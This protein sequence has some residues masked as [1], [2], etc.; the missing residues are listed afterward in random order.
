M[1][2]DL[3]EILVPYTGGAQAL[4]ATTANK[5]VRLFGQEVST[6]ATDTDGNTSSATVTAMPVFDFGGGAAGGGVSDPVIRSASVTT[7]LY[8]HS[9]PPLSAGASSER[10]AAAIWMDTRVT[11]DTGGDTVVKVSVAAGGA[12]GG[13][14]T[15]PV[16]TDSTALF[17]A[18][19]TNV[20]TDSDSRVKA[21][22]FAS[23]D[24]VWNVSA[25]VNTIGSLPT[26]SVNVNTIGSLP[27]QIVNVNTIGSLPTASVNVNTIGSLPAVN[28]AANQSISANVTRIVTNTDSTALYIAS[29][30]D[31]GAESDTIVAAAVYATNICSRKSN[32]PIFDNADITVTDAADVTTIFS[33]T[34]I[35]G[36]ADACANVHMTL[37]RRSSTDGNVGRVFLIPEARVV[38]N[39]ANWDRY[40]FGPWQA[41]GFRGTAITN[42]TTFSDNT[43]SATVTTDA[44]RRCWQIPMLGTAM[45]IALSVE[46]INSTK[47][48]TLN[49]QA[50]VQNFPGF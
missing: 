38:D 8:V 48:L 11:G 19:D 41:L 40:D 23:Q 3:R 33:E 12:G 39:A 47:D 30:T 32:Q 2:T 21:A 25:N 22:V 1:G 45:R 16:Q 50:Q 5:I 24:G 49:L 9:N 35:T 34:F 43:G 13:N 18:T 6:T 10:A 7:N 46:G 42:E 29:D 4:S 27:T 15:L 31:V 28:V 14:V 44:I 37:A 20:G 26:Q 17:V 36:P